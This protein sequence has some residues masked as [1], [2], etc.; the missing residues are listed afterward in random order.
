MIAISDAPALAVVLGGGVRD[1]KPHP[2]T[3]ERARRAGELARARPTIAVIL[4]GRNGLDEPDPPRSEAQL[5]ADMLVGA[6]VAAQRLAL[7]DES[8]DTLGNALLT[9]VRY[10][11]GV[12]PRPIALVTSPFHMPRAALVFGHVLGPTWPTELVPSEEVD[13]DDARAAAEPALI[14]E[15]RELLRGTEA[16]DVGGIARRVRETLPYY[17]GLERIRPERL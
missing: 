2:M 14:A 6:G 5:M 4:S 8:R 13:G 12:E 3:I 16:G 11:R 9:A 7:E 17:R 15:T 1:G 10:L